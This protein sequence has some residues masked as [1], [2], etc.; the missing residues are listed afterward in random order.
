MEK[1]RKK[2]LPSLL[3]IREGRSWSCCESLLAWSEEW[4]GKGW[5]AR[6]Y[7]EKRVTCHW[8]ENQ[9]K[10]SHVNAQKKRRGW[11]PPSPF[12]IMS[13]SH[14]MSIRVSNST[15]VDHY[16][17]LITSYSLWVT[18]YELLIMSYSYTMS[19]WESYS[20]CVAHY[21]LLK[22]YTMSIWVSNSTCVAHYELLVHELLIMSYWY[23][24]SIWVSNS[25]TSRVTCA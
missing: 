25:S 6:L 11:V 16:E 19:I 7:R 9:W 1:K 10:M 4:N 23:T 17:L 13:Y 24:M 12:L 22:T 8:V 21:E 5:V 3:G 14:T 20:T 18:H 2:S 15:C